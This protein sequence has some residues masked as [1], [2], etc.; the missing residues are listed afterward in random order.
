MKRRDFSR[1]SFQY[2]GDLTLKSDRWNT[3]RSFNKLKGALL[4]PW[5]MLNRPALSVDVV[6]ILPAE[7]PKEVN[8]VKSD[9][10]LHR[11]PAS[12]NAVVLEGYP[13]SSYVTVTWSHALCDG[14]SMM[15]FISHWAEAYRGQKLEMFHRGPFES[16]TQ[17][18]LECIRS[19]I[20]REALVPAPCAGN[21]FVFRR[22]F[23][24][25][26]RLEGH[27]KTLLG[28]QGSD[29]LASLICL[30]LAKQFETEVHISFMQDMRHH[31][32]ELRAFVGNLSR[33]S[34][35][36]A[37]RARSVEA[38]SSEVAALRRDTSGKWNMKAVASEGKFPGQP[39]FLQNLEAYSADQG[40]V[41]LVINDLSQYEALF[42]FDP[43][44]PAA[45]TS[46]IAPTNYESPH[47][48]E[49]FSSFDLPGDARNRVWTAIFT[50]VT[51]NEEGIQVTLMSL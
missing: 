11:N 33:L 15:A 34:E 27:G 41:N 45:T 1:G 39:C 12:P 2:G 29:I 42:N 5:E 4:S 17:K 14:P 19:I 50:K 37:V 26:S 30:D 21:S 16:F 8:K 35:P 32:P 18:D 51:R 40:S 3:I 24:S 9:D 43:K 46:E 36:K 49:E 10:D 28:V 7:K 38:L 13:S 31:L 44:Q 20:E 22:R 48:W 6:K 47:C 25:R 23:F